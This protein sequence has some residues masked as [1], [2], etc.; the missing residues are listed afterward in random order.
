MLGAVNEDFSA[1][2]QGTRNCDGDEPENLCDKC[3]SPK[4]ANQ[5]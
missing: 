1:V 3:G 5:Q 2:K 4:A